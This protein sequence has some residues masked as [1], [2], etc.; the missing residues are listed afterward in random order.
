MNIDVMGRWAVPGAVGLCYVNVVQ[1]WRGE[2]G[3]G[4]SGGKVRGKMG[5]V[6]MALTAHGVILSTVVYSLSLS[7]LLFVADCLLRGLGSRFRIASSCRFQD[8][9]AKVFDY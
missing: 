1:E 3:A 2:G 9:T 5:A 4:G 8:L 6:R 7:A